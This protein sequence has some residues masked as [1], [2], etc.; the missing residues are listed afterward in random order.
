ME[1]LSFDYSKLKG[2]IVEKIGSQKAFAKLLGISEPTLT[3]RMNGY[4]EFS[5][6]EIYRSA[7]ILGIDPGVISLYFF[8][9][10]V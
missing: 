9:K 5:Q 3:S 1:N 4:T 6:K 10:R 2:R 7:E 8:A